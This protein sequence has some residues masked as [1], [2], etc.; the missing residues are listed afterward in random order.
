MK[1]FEPEFR[2]IK[3][4]T[5]NRYYYYKV[6]IRWY[7]SLWCWSCNY[8]TKCGYVMNDK[9]EHFSFIELANDLINDIKKDIAKRK[10]VNKIEIVE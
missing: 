4:T 8:V 7:K 6:E 3:V 5:F 2:I 10:F 1:L 9:N